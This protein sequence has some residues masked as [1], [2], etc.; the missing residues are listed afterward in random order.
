MADKI[1]EIKDLRVN[2]RQT[3]KQWR[4][5]TVSIWKS[6]RAELSDWLGKPVRERPQ[7]RFRSCVWLPSTT[8][9]ILNG[10]I[11]FEG[12]NLLEIEEEKMRKIR[13]DKIA[14]VFQDPMTSLNPVQTVGEQIAEGIK[15][16]NEEM[17]KE[18]V[19]K[20]VE[21]ILSM[22][23]DRTKTKVRLSSPVFRRDETTGGYCHRP[24]L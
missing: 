15:L 20:R 16:H 8:G 9:R 3:W 22:V 5:L 19:E 14:M 21:E 23:W 18:D 1:L 12:E 6:K 24:F 7:Q 10:E 17:S 4:P 11:I 2:Y 13:G